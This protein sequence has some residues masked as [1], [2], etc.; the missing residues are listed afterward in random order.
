MTNIVLLGLVSFFSDISAEMVYPLIP[1][2][3]TSAFG[4]TP[5]LVGIVEGIAESIASLLKVF[6][7]YISDKYKRKKALAFSGYSTGVI[8]K[9]AL[10]IATSWTGILFA[11][12]IDRIGKGIRTAPRDVLVCESAEKNGMGK[13]FGIHKALDM[14]GAA[15]GILIA[16]LL[17]AGDRTSFDYQTLFAL[18]IVPAILGLLMLLFVKEKKEHTA[19]K[20]RE[21][22]WKKVKY[23]DR[24]LKLYLLVTLI[25]TLGNS[26]NAFLILRA[27]SLG[28]S[29]GSVIL[30]YFIYNITAALFSIPFGKLSDRL[31]RKKVLVSGYLV[32]ALVY[33]GFAFVKD[34]EIL[35]LL[36]IAYGLYTAMTAGVE[37]AL[38][39]EISPPELKGTML[40]LQATIVGIALLPASVIAGLLWNVCGAA[41]PFL[42]GAVLA[43]LS[44]GMLILLMNLNL[45]N[46][47]E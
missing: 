32:F 24:N 45:H 16:Y 8:Y 9:I 21:A 26:S 40:G 11:R 47:K 44:A 34:T 12:V 6:S 1:L 7:G 29:D 14:A 27:K 39:S 17:L 5:A 37:R 41:A 10:M 3:L 36:F 25:F 13:A 38:I 28:I 23:L 22:F 46:D 19:I 31:G 43:I 30:L 15:L 42:L 4:A 2:Y 35:T 33:F 20:N 18:S